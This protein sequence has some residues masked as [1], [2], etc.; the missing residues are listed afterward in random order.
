[1]SLVTAF[2][3]VRLNNSDINQ[4][5]Y[6]FFPLDTHSSAGLTF[7]IAAGVCGVASAAGGRLPVWS[8]QMV[9]C[10]GCP[11]R[12]WGSLNG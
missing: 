6:L 7:A 10:P 5:F 4:S 1:M 12:Q 9:A 8:Q 2:F 11:A 3:P